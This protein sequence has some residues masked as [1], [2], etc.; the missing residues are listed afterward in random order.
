MGSVLTKENGKCTA[1][2]I[3]L[4][5]SIILAIIGISLI[6]VIPLIGTGIGFILGIFAII[7]FI[8]ALILLIKMLNKKGFSGLSG[9]CKANIVFCLVVFI[10]VIT[11]II[12]GSIKH[13]ENQTDPLITP[14]PTPTPAIAK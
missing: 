6:F 5:F 7:F 12:S 13:S 10:L 1:I 4:S 9:W 3:L 14:T 8:I 11:G 2:T